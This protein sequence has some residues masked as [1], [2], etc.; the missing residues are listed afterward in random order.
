MLKRFLEVRYS[1]IN[2]YYNI[3]KS[4]RRSCNVNLRVIIKWIERYLKK[5]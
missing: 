2:S 3:Y 5:F 1:D 4:L